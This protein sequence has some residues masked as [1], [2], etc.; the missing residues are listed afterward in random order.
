MGKGYAPRK[1]SEK[2]AW[3]SDP[4]SSLSDVRDYWEETTHLYLQHGTTFQGGM[5]SDALSEV[6]VLKNRSS[7]AAAPAV[8]VR[9][10]HC[11]ALNDESDKFCGQCGR[12]LV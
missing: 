7:S 2:N 12:A 6:D 11:K 9:C 1:A 4:T 3:R 10:P 8:K 5:L